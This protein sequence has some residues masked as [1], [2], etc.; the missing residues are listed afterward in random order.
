L[1]FGDDNDLGRPKQ[2][3]TTLCKEK[4]INRKSLPKLELEVELIKLFQAYDSLTFKELCEH[5]PK[6]PEKALMKSVNS[7]ATFNT[8]KKTYSLKSD[9]TKHLGVKSE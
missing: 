5:L 8:L 3:F 2:L 1:C 7:L 9:I 6:Q 4:K